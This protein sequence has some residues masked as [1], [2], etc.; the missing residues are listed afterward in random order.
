M[1]TDPSDLVREFHQFFGL[2]ARTRDEL[3]RIEGEELAFRRRLL[4]EE[5]EELDEALEDNNDIAH[6]YKEMADLAYVLYGLDQH[7]GG[8]LSAVLEEV[9]RSNMT[10]LWS[11]DNCGGRGTKRAGTIDNPNNVVECLVCNGSGKMAK[12]REDGKVLKPPTYVKPDLS[13]VL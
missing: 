12:Y 6:I 3:T 2:P 8:R 9:H 10:K 11:C 1:P 5:Y 4:D 13:A 7:L